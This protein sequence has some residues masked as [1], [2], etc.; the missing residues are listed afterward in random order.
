MPA[1]VCSTGEQKALLIGLVLAHADHIRRH[2]DGRTP[3]LLLDEMT[4]ALPAD[5]AERVLDVV[6]RQSRSGRSVIFISHRLLEISAL[7]DRATVL[8]DGETVGVST[9][10]GYSSNERAMLSLASI[11]VAAAEPGNE[12][13]LVWGEE[14]GGTRKITVERHRQIELRVTVAPAP[15][16]SAAREGY[17]ST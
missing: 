4:A 5:L 12:L 6:K 15:Y 11:D 7:C 17:R 10:A 8:R 9:W 14:N 3:V 1:S 2:R 13:T 16:A